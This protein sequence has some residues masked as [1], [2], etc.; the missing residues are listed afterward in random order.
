MSAAAGAVY[1]VFPAEDVPQDHVHP[2]VPRLAVV[3]QGAG[4]VAVGVPLVPGLLERG[5][6]VPQ[7]VELAAA[8][9]LACP[10]ATPA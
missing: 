8:G 2:G 5:L 7:R 4:V 3:L 9:R 1:E 6:G 10:A